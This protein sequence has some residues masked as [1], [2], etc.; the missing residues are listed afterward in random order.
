MN[1][2]I[3]AV[4]YSDVGS[5]LNNW[6]LLGFRVLLAVELLW[7][8]G[9]KKLRKTNGV[10]ESIPNPLGLPPTLNNL[11][12]TVSD[13]VVPF[14]VMAG[15][16]TRLVVLPVIGVTAIGYAVVHR[17]D[18]PQV[19]DIPFMYTLC[20]LLLLLLGAGTRS[21]DQYLWSIL[22]RSYHF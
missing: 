12:A 5:E 3:K 22:N 15:V 14:L 17:H 11:V 4:L 10:P 21:V 6:A 16:A 13:T 18:S 1:D 8:H 2:L 7:V 19:R 9:L 20:F